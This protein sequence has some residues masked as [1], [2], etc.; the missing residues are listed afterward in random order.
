MIDAE[1]PSKDNEYVKGN[2]WGLENISG[3]VRVDPRQTTEHKAVGGR[4]TKAQL[5]YRLRTKEQI[6]RRIKALA[7]DTHSREEVA[8]QAKINLTELQEQIA[9]L[10]EEIAAYPD[11]NDIREFQRALDNPPDLGGSSDGELIINDDDRERIQAYDNLQSITQMRER[12]PSVIER[13]E[14]KLDFS[15]VQRLIDTGTSVSTVAAAMNMPIE[16]LQEE[17]ASA[18]EEPVS[19][20]MTEID[21]LNSLG[22]IWQN[23]NY[24]AEPRLRRLF[25]EELAHFY[26]GKVP[27]SAVARLEVQDDQPVET[28]E[29]EVE[30]ITTQANENKPSVLSVLRRIGSGKLKPRA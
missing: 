27:V 13:L 25:L 5:E 19:T 3:G 9:T 24:T 10:R 28:A 23:A 15:L 22:H 4:E 6:L 18:K 7:N 14:R 26:D 20:K 17:L 12:R 2:Y 8:N 1:L 29:P 16:R 11:S 30:P 21:F